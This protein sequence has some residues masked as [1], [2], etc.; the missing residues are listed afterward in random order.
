MKS[1]VLKTAVVDINAFETNYGIWHRLNV[2]TQPDVHFPLPRCSRIIP[3]NNAYW[4]STKSPSDTTTKNIDSCDEKLGVRTPQTLTVAR[5]QQL[6]VHQFYRGCQMLTAKDDL[7]EWYHTVRHYRDAASHRLT[8]M[9]AFEECKGFLRAYIKSASIPATVQVHQAMQ[10]TSP[11]PVRRPRRGVVHTIKKIGHAVRNGI[12]P[13]RN[14]KQTT[15]QLALAAKRNDDCL[16]LCLLPQAAVIDTKTGKLNPKK[17]LKRDR[18]ALCGQLTAM[19]CTGCNRSFCVNKDRMATLAERGHL[20]AG[21]SKKKIIMIPVLNSAT[22]EMESKWFIR[23]CYQVAHE[24]RW[25]E[26][27]E[28][29]EDSTRDLAIDLFGTDE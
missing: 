1:K 7:A 10:P 17:E 13:G 9:A 6:K 24:K 25:E 15:E 27:W 26:Y 4:N 16:G 19:Y 29:N 8:F 2:D 23:S 28:A 3:Y 21:D 18:C 12:T 22:G 11:I 14:R 20:E 5:M